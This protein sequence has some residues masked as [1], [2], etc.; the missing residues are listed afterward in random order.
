MRH[1]GWQEEF[2]LPTSTV[3]HSTVYE[4]IC[5][6]VQPIE[7]LGALHISSNLVWKFAKKNDFSPKGLRKKK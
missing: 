6:Y 2:R 3:L 4:N 1:S 5:F 7:V